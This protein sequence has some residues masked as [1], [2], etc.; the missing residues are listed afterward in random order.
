[1]LSTQEQYNA[2]VRVI[3]EYQRRLL[4]IAGELDDLVLRDRAYLMKDYL[5]ILESLAGKG[6]STNEWFSH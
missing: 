5:A 1:M 3:Q 4:E 2:H 6:G